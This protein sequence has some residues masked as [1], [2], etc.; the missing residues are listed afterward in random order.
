MKLALGRAAGRFAAIVAAAVTVSFFLMLPCAASAMTAQPSLEVPLVNGTIEGKRMR[1]GETDLRVFLGI[2]YAAPPIGTLRWREPKPVERWAGVRRAI[3]F[4]PRCMQAP[5]YEI[6]FRSA[7]MSED[8]LYL[9]VW[10]PASGQEKKLPV[11]VYFHG[12]NFDVGDGSEPRYDGGN[13]AARGI[14]TVTLNY[15]LGAFGFLA[16]PELESESPHGTAGNYGLLDQHAALE[17]VR[18]NIAAFGGDP[19]QVTIAGDSAGAFSVSTHM[20]SPLSRGLFAR[21]VGFSGGAFRPQLALPRDLA[22]ALSTVFSW[23]SGRTSVESLRAAPADSILAVT[24]LT[25]H[26]AI[27]FWPSVDGRFLPKA[28]GGIFASGSQAHVPLLVG[29]DLYVGH[30]D[31]ALK[32][33]APTPQNWQHVLKERFGDRS[34][35]AHALYPG[36]SEE[37]I[38]RSASALAG[39]EWVGHSA[40]R[41]MTRHRQTSLARIYFYGYTHRHPI[42]PNEEDFPD[43]VVRPW[44]AKEALFALDNLDSR[45]SYPWSADDRE[46]SRVF[47]GHVEQFIK[48]GNPNRAGLPT[49]PAVQDTREGSLRHAIGADKQRAAQ[50]VDARHALLEA[51]YAVRKAGALAR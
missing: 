6:T 51:S 22:R 32:G 42:A 35:E 11:L 1:V 44:N 17:W 43:P 36:Q 33:A 46:I 5:P 3:E 31:M 16:L 24:G 38:K 19:A 7:Q 39:D 45:P 2:P 49:W 21:A 47:S 41:W 27:A 30:H 29:S 37:E 18:D 8:C 23:T 26:P 13:L 28:P 14:V 20:A 4:G 9:N 15:R 50:D 40:R 34:G 10:T 48:D 25:G 12:G